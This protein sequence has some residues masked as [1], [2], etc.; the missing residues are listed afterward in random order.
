[1][2][3]A[4]GWSP[5]AAPAW[6]ALLL[7]APRCAATCRAVQGWHNEQTHQFLA[8]YSAIG[9]H[10]QHNFPAQEFNSTTSDM[11]TWLLKQ[12]TPASS[13]AKV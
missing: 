2:L 1:M 8:L 13:S 6:G 3:A 5:A 12:Q 9:H 7:V 4:A 11:L 10:G